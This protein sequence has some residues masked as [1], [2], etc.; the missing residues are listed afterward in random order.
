MNFFLKISGKDEPQLSHHVLDFG[1]GLVTLL[2]LVVK[3]GP[4]I[5]Q[6]LRHL[7]QL[8][9]SDT[10]LDAHAGD[11]LAC[12]F[13]I[14][15]EVHEGVEKLRELGSHGARDLAQLVADAIGGGG[16]DIGKTADGR[17]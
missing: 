9:A 17:L 8:G 14:E 12:V 16:G 5:L 4:G 3:Q 10:R 1:L 15:L 2:L 11:C 7:V 6:L 13:S